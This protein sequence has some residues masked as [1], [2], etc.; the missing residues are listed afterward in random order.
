MAIGTPEHFGIQG[1][2]EREE[3]ATFGVLTGGATSEIIGGAGAVVLAILGLA[4]VAPA[5]MFPIATIAV[6]GA[7]FLQG[8]A[9]MARF[10]RIAA[11][12]A[13]NRQENVE[14]GN[15]ASA[16]FL[17]GA[18]GIALG[19]LALIGLMP[20]TLCAIAVIVFGGCM[21][22]GS[23]ETARLRDLHFARS[24]SHQQV[25]YLARQAT[26]SA[27]GGEALVGLAAIALGILALT[28]MATLTLTLVALLCL[29]AQIVLS[30]SSI[31]TL[32]CSGFFR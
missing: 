13:Q 3:T 8:G 22:I 23:G 4:N 27:A 11:D 14:L 30:G 9:V 21:L 17:G 16:Q 1:K 24:H 31:S 6:G 26:M 20:L 5:Y 10:S 19:V 15:G 7:M 18:A 28:G 25:E 2:G 29:G 32:L 12:V